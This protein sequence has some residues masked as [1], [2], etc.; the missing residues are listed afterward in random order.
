MLF[1]KITTSIKINATYIVVFLLVS[2]GALSYAS[3]LHDSPTTDEAQ[4]IAAGYINFVLHDYRINMEKPPLFRLLSAPLLM[5]ADPII[6]VTDKSWEEG[7]IS[8][9]DFGNAFFYLYG[10]DAD[11]I[12]MIARIPMVMLAMGL[13]L[14]LYL[15]T[16][17]L[18][19]EDAAL[20][21]VFL[22]AF[23]PSFLAHGKYVNTDVPA[24]F[25]FVLVVYRY[26]CFM[27][28]TSRIEAVLLGISI[29]ISVML[30]QSVLLVVFWITLFI[31]ARAFFLMFHK[32]WREV[33]ILVG[34][35]VCA[36]MVA[37]LLIY[38]M[39]W[40]ASY[41][42]PESVM[43][44]HVNSFMY[45]W[46]I[47]LPQNVVDLLS[48]RTTRPLGLFVVGVL[49]E[50]RRVASYQVQYFLGEYSVYGGWRTYFPI[51]YLLKTPIAFH[52]VS[53]VA[54]VGAIIDFSWVKVKAI[55]WE[56]AL[57]YITMAVVVGSYMLVAIYSPL[58][59]GV[60]HIIPLLPYVMI[61]VAIG[62]SGV[63]RKHNLPLMVV[64][65]VA[66]VS[67]LW[68]GLSEFPHYLSYF[69]QIS[70]GTRKGYEISV[71]SDYSWDQDYKRFGEWVRENGVEKIPVDCGYGRD[72]AFNY[73]AKDF[74]EPFR[75]SSSWLQESS[76]LQDI[77][78]LSK[79]DLLGVCVPIL[80][81]GYYV[82]EGQEFHVRY[83]YQTL[84]NM[85]P[86]DRVGTSIFIYRF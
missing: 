22:F 28:K 47:V 14:I 16:K 86:I 64:L 19:G 40:F 5:F 37:L 15:F 62:C 31:S 76:K 39:Y 65:I 75:G 59:I 11:L 23:S 83:D 4:H 81:G 52:V 66:G 57:P 80:Y 32:N 68:V 48:N 10:N 51:L 12:L 84:R 26:W 77:S 33:R 79:G 38:G 53:V 61:I 45:R 49:R 1:N 7:A 85:Q 21:V 72:A 29:G 67:Y 46:Q 2:Y 70:G 8:S 74:T 82:M 43:F 58:N 42:Y 20:I 55:S 9:W 24:A 63:I 54:F 3:G 13:G 56:N 44:Q 73:Y 25:G 34:E 69:N 18:A 36:A 41:L 30:K 71:S 35:T 78:E 50:M 17:E 60:R 27:K 6:P